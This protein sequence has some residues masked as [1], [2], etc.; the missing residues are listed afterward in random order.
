VAT[1]TRLNKTHDLFRGVKVD[2]PEQFK[3]AVLNS[4]GPGSSS[5]GSGTGAAEGAQLFPGMGG[6][7]AGSVGKGAHK[8]QVLELFKLTKHLR[9]VFGA[10]RGEHG[11]YLRAAEVS[12]RCLSGLGF[13]A[14]CTNTAPG[15]LS[16][17]LLLLNSCTICNRCQ[18]LRSHVL[19]C[20]IFCYAGT[21][22]PND[23]HQEPRLGE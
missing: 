9:D 23:V 20:L 7:A 13:C 18:P 10:P 8:V 4:G 11:E 1:V 17:I 6:G 3:A 2:N 12:L 5:A 14:L 22:H 16:V 15:T 21:R 19:K